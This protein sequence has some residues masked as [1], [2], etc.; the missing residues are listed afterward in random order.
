MTFREVWSILDKKDNEE[1]EEDH[2][3]GKKKKKRKKE[4]CYSTEIIENPYKSIY[5]QIYT[6]VVL[7][8]PEYLCTI[9]RNSQIM[10]GYAKLFKS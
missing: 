1:I 2:Q 10:K 9:N 6:H 3:Q 4:N 8:F 5:K 7:L